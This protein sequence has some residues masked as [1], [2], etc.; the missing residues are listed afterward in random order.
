MKL[1]KCTMGKI[2]CTKDSSGEIERIGMVKGITTIYPLAG[3]YERKKED[4]AIPFIERSS[5]D[6]CGIH[7]HNLYEYKG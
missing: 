5:G 1:S 6:S 7:H 4:H 2:V 3:Y